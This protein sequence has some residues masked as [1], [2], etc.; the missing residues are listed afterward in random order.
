MPTPPDRQTALPAL[1]LR[2]AP[3]LQLATAGFSL[4]TASGVLWHY[5]SGAAVEGA[6]DAPVSGVGKGGLSGV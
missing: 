1:L 2:R 5:A 3:L 4:G 6:P